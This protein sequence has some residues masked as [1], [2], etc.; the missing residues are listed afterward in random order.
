M[1]YCGVAAGPEWQHLCT[2]E[3]V[4]TPEPPIRLE[5]TFYEPGTA[6]Q[7]AARIHAMGDVVVAVGAPMTARAERVC[8]EELRRRGVAPHP[9]LDAARALYESL[10]DLGL[11]APDADPGQGRIEEGAFAEAAV[12]ETNIEA[13][14]CAL[15][16]RRAPA[17]R[18]PFGVAMRIDELEQDHVVDEGGGLWSRRI[19]E[20]EAAAAALC[21]HRYAVA[22]A[23]WAG[24]PR[25]GVVVLPGL[26]L[27]E[28]F[29][30]EGAVPPAAR[31]PLAG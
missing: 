7:V 3:E 31:V 16:G 19:D 11:Y 26:S 8:D 24:D 6:A 15:H 18:H 13:V 14:F 5:A 27:P 2:L 25:E 21:A 12:F 17:K 10:S 29:A 9:P 22:H 20:I 30:V 4:R 23:C 1:R 28:R